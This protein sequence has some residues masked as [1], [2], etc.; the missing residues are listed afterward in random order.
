MQLRLRDDAMLV[1]GGNVADKGSGTTPP[2]P[3]SRS[4]FEKV[5]FSFILC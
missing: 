3:H 4:P 1:Y 5:N 2:S